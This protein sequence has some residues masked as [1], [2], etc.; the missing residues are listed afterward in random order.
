MECG[1]YY[2]NYECIK[3]CEAEYGNG[4]DFNPLDIL[5]KE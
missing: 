3:K 2:Y 1:D 4:F 5:K